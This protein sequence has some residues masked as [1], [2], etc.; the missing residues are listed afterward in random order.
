MYEVAMDRADYAAAH[1][2]LSR[3]V[4]LDPDDEAARARLKAFEDAMGDFVTP[5]EPEEEEAS[6]PEE[7]D[8]GDAIELSARIAGSVADEMSP[9]AGPRRL[10]SDDG[11]DEMDFDDAEMQ[12]LAAQLAREMKQKEA[13][14]QEAHGA[15]RANHASGGHA[16]AGVGAA[17]SAPSPAEQSPVRMPGARPPA[18]GAQSDAGARA[19]RAAIEQADEDLFGDASLEALARELRGEGLMGDG[20]GDGEAVE[21]ATQRSGDAAGGAD[22]DDPFAGIDDVKT[23]GEI[24]AASEGVD[25]S[26]L[27]DLGDLGELDDLLSSVGNDE[28]VRRMTTFDLAKSYYDTGMY[29]DAAIEF[30]R[31]VDE[32]ERVPEALELLGLSMRR[33]RNFKG[34]VDAFRR[35][36]Q[37]APTDTDQVLRVMF[38]LGVTYEAA[39]SRHSAYKIYR[40]IVEKRRNFREGEVVNR[41]AS[42]ALEL[43]IRE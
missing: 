35:L 38:E 25:M 4:E 7:R 43:G 22:A 12:R 24:G 9:A 32:G 18:T 33:N 40:K 20:G 23:L 26:E 27:G 21:D 11:T 31:C 37:E 42:L 10:D 34:A 36:L 2:C 30:Q 3:A 14:R 1:L 6:E 16:G 17:A 41:V 15:A 39:G 13:A 5:K 29:E 19:S 28:P 8:L